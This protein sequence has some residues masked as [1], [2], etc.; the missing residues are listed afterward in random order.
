METEIASV[1]SNIEVIQKIFIPLIDVGMENPA[2]NELYELLFK[3]QYFLEKKKAKKQKLTA[4]I[5]KTETETETDR[6]IV[7]AYFLDFLNLYPENPFIPD[8]VKRTN[9]EKR[10]IAKLEKTHNLFK[11]ASVKRVWDEYR[12]IT[13]LKESKT[14]FTRRK[15]QQLFRV[16][17][18][19]LEHNFTGKPLDSC[20]EACEFIARDHELKYN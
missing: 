12:N 6:S 20:N 2:L 15:K 1:K 11:G 18:L 16:R 5:T 10:H 3:Y 14:T 9:S 13:T 17:E 7:L 4:S 8:E 19:L